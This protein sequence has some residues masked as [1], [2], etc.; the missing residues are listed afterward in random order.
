MEVLQAKVPYLKGDIKL[1]C[2]PSIFY[3]MCKQL[4]K[5]QTKINC[6]NVDYLEDIC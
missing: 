3:N 1:F 5:N 2:V 6:Q 4:E